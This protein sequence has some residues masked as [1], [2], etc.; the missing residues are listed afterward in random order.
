[1]KKLNLFIILI[2]TVLL[3]SCEKEQDM[4][5]VLP[6][7]QAGK[8]V[9]A[10]HD[11]IVIKLDNLESTTT[12][13][14]K[15]AD[16]GVPA[17]PEYTLYVKTGED[18][19]AQRV[20]SAFADSLDVK[21]E[22][23]NKLLIAAGLEP[24]KAADVNFF[25]EASLYSEY[26]V[27]SELIKLKVTPF[28]PVYPDA[29]Y[30]I[31]QAFGGWDW[32]NPKI[33]EMTPV[34]GHAGKFWAVRHFANPGDGFKWNTKKDWG[35]DFFSLGKDVGFTTEGGNAFVSEAGFYIVLI[36]YTINTITIEPAQVYGMG[37][38]F[39]GWNT[40]K[41]PF[42][43]DGNEMKITTANSGDLRIYANSS[44]AGV[45]GDWWRMEFILRDGKIE[46][47]GNGDDQEPRVNVGAGKTVTLDFNSGTGTVN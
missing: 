17:A 24:G 30:M 14:W 40:G 7:E 25:V 41:Y 35:G 26:K 38:C 6:A 37:D 33:V 47:R 27:T 43:A 34:N 21:L 42:T 45:G 13:K 11:D 31:G 23:L 5:R 2:V 44:A 46:Y 32:G 10:A 19:D 22:D 36:D 3:F 9:L 16:L 39:G 12:F 4:Y 29:V 15:K 18:K 1:M 20:S 8:P 28:K